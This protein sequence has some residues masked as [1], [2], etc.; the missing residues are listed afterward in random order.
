MT[1]PPLTPEACGPD[2]IFFGLRSA[3]PW[4][5]IDTAYT[6]GRPVDPAAYVPKTAIPNFPSNIVACI[7]AWNATF[8]VNYF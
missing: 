8:Q 5:E 7:E 1:A 2:R 3:P 6:S 4:S